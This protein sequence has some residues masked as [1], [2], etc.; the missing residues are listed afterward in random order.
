MSRIALFLMVLAAL[1]VPAVFAQGLPPLDLQNL[2]VP[3]S[4]AW[5]MTGNAPAIIDRP[6][7]PRAL[8][9]A[10]ANATQNGSVLPEDY[11]LEFA[12]YWL[13]KRPHL[14]FSQFY[15]PSLRQ[16]VLQ[17]AGLSLAFR[18]GSGGEEIIGIG[19]RTLILP[20]K[21]SRQLWQAIREIQT[22]QSAALIIGSL[23]LL[24]PLPSNRREFMEALR[25]QFEI[26]KKEPEKFDW[27]EMPERDR[28]LLIGEIE[29]LAIRTATEYFDKQGAKAAEI[30]VEDALVDLELLLT[31]KIREEG[32]RKLQEAERGRRGFVLES[33]IGSRLL[34]PEQILEKMQ[35]QLFSIWLTAGYQ[36]EAAP[37]GVVFLTRFW[38]GTKKDAHTY[39]DFGAAFHWQNN[40]FSLAL[41]WLQRQ[42]WGKAVA[43]QRAELL[44]PYISSSRISLFTQYRLQPG[45][46]LQFS[47]GKDF[48]QRNVKGNLIARLGIS[49]GLGKRFLD[50]SELANSK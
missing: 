17:H 5:V 48:K 11:G 4:P 2:R 31:E 25:R 14:T 8:A 47:F 15:R 13:K 29:Q 1:P 18:Q 12:P 40:A 23:A 44:A 6:E 46:Y 24:E 34:V 38:S 30:A 43:E 19:L 3:A 42:E 45:I 28:L 22:V 41:E 49:M 37:W 16:S 27:P 39:L 36:K 32:I 21:A 9:L 7:T 26:L 33:G 10:L 20:G 35:M 50:M